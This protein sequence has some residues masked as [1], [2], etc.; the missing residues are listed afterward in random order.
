MNLEQS[1][2][3][4]KFVPGKT[5]EEDCFRVI[6]QNLLKIN[7]VIMKYKLLKIIEL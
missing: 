6:I 4:G 1:S 2:M 7:E 5:G 3:L